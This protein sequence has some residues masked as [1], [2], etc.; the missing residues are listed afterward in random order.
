M[1]RIEMRRYLRMLA[2]LV[3]VAALPAAITAWKQA[4]ALA[5]ALADE[6]G[7]VDRTTIGPA[8]VER[9]PSTHSTPSRPGPWHGAD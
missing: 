8:E 4:S 6:F 7:S 9:L 3:A 5:P 1:Y 2:I